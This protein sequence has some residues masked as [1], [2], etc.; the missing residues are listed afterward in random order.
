[1]K[2]VPG[3][4]VLYSAAVRMRPRYPLAPPPIIVSFSAALAPKSCFNLERLLKSGAP[5]ILG[6]LLVK[7]AMMVSTSGT[8]ALVMLV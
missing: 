3:A 5:C 1:M 7:D 2:G 4:M 8:L 6:I